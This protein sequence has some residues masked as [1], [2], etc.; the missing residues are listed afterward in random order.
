[1]PAADRE[2]ILRYFSHEKGTKV[3]MHKGLAAE[4]GININTLRLR[5]L[6][7]K[8]KLQPCVERCLEHTEVF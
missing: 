4:L 1:L 8:Q 3:D 6:R 2:M 5:V 7:T